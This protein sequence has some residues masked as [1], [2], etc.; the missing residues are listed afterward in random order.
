MAEL[1]TGKGGAK[2]AGKPAA[3]DAAKDSG[4]GGCEGR[5]QGKEARC[6]RPGGDG[7]RPRQAEPFAPTHGLR[8]AAQE[9]L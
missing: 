5:G 4:E 8:A 3:K 9:T 1:K 2:G 7:A 6:R